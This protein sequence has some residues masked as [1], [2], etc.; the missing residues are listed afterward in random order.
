MIWHYLYG[1]NAVAF[2]LLVGAG[3]GAT[4]RRLEKHLGRKK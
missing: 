3:V 4:L 1:I 2:A